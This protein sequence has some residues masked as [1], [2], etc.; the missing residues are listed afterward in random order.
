MSSGAAPPPPHSSTPSPALGQGYA[1]PHGA[2]TSKSNGGLGSWQGGQDRPLGHFQDLSAQ[3]LQGLDT[4]QS[5][6]RLVQTAEASIRQA[7]ML[8]DARRPDRAFVEYLRSFQIVLECIPRHN[9]FLDFKHGKSPTYQTYQSTLKRV[10]NQTER[11]DKIKQIIQ[12]DNKRRGTQPMLPS[13]LQPGA[14]RPATPAHGATSQRPLSMAIPPSAQDGAGLLSPPRKPVG[15]S[16]E[17]DTSDGSHSPRPKPTPSPKPQS[18]HGNAIASNGAVSNSTVDALNDRF[19]R[20]R[21]MP[22]QSRLD[23]S[24]GNNRPDSTASYASSGADG[25]PVTMSPI[26]GFN[27][28]SSFDVSSPVKSNSSLRG[29]PSGRPSG[30]RAMPNG[31]PVKSPFGADVVAALPR[32]PDA[33]YNPARNMRISGNIEPPRSSARSIVGTGGRSNSIASS[34]SSIAPGTDSEAA[35]YFPIPSSNGPPAGP[36]R[37][38]SVHLPKE[39]RIGADKLYDYLKMHNILLIDVRSREEY[40]IGHIYAQS[41]MCVEPTA[42]RRDMSADELLEALVLSPENEQDMFYG[43][44]NYDLVVYYDQST[45]S[46]QFLTRPATSQEFALR[47][48][49]DALYEYNHDKPLQRPP[50]LLMGGI[51]AWTDLVGD[52]ALKTSNTAA[53]IKGAK[54][55]RRVPVANGHSRLH[56]PKKRLRDYN[57]LDAEEERSWLERARSESVV[58]DQQEVRDENGQ[59]IEEGEEEQAPYYQ[60]IEDFLQ[61]FPDADTIGRQ[62]MTSISGGAHRP[63]P[64]IP[65]Y[66]APPPP[67]ALP[68]APSRPAPAVPRM[69]YSGVNERAA[70]QGS[71]TGRSAELP[72]YISPR[73]LPSNLRLPRT[74][75]VNFGVTC[76]MNATIQAL[77]A[78]IPLSSFFMDGDSFKKHVQRENWKGSKGVLPELYANLIRSIWKGDVEA[79]RPSTLR[80]FCARL[81][82][83]WGIDRQQ[84][85]KEFFDFLVDCLHE[86]LNGRWSKPPLREL[87]AQEEAKRE[88]M[89]K[90]IVAKTE[91]DRYTHR[92]QS[93]LTDLFAG[94]HASRLRCTTCHFTSTTYE[95]FYS[96]SVE[97]PRSGRSSIEECLRSYCAEEMLSGDEVW[98]CPRCNVEREA[99]KQITITRAPQFLVVHFKRFSAGRGESARKVRTPIEFPLKGLDIEPYMLP[100]PSAVEAESIAKQFGPE[101]LKTGVEMTPPYRYDAYAVM[102]HIGT[103]LTSGHYTCLARDQQRDCW[104]QFND[105][106]V[107]DFDPDRL[108]E[109]ERL[110][111][112]MAYIVFYQRAAVP[113]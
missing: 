52:Q 30:P 1:N 93:Y 72:A 41:T 6:A 65:S 29:L 81:N 70:S 105:T 38:K 80:S 110:Q 113:K 50:V 19:A 35:G 57:P 66:P 61:R 102:R 25:S 62:S 106:W 22:G 103:T 49:H 97:I 14:Q 5:I 7:E 95:A 101:A 104:R 78:T 98:K 63:P 64:Q 27:G 8:V 51:D 10:V 31:G 13:S 107:G 18:L 92:E 37:R 75:L 44:N 96:I 74:G 39:T 9:D 112:E 42:L 24:M 99:T 86:D 43:R 20:L 108:S 59:P 45:L 21:M 77:S 54:P 69:S 46:D 91:W 2:G 88:S 111:N 58:V 55:I 76:Y 16:A 73:Y 71:L 109:R 90:L 67:S 87:T 84:D 79:I 85:A 3:A 94:Q 68:Q 33:A 15:S 12:N 26:N 60:N 47:Y 89:P 17:S 23:T 100:R 48:L 53:K 32:A 34:A 36:P 28:R 4:N 83:E 40:D 11:W 82:R 56:V